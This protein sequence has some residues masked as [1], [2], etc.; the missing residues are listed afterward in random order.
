MLQ[1]IW[2]IL[3]NFH[4]ENP[5]PESQ[6]RKT[7]KKRVLQKTGSKLH[8]GRTSSTPS[9]LCDFK[10]LENKTG[11][12]ATVLCVLSGVPHLWVARASFWG[13]TGP[14]IGDGPSAVLFRR[15]A[16]LGGKWIS[17][18]AARFARPWRLA[19]LARHGSLRS[20]ARFARTGR[21]ASL[22]GSLLGRHGSLR[23]AARFA[24]TGRLASLGGSLR[25]LLASRIARPSLFASLAR[26]GSLRSA[27]RFARTGPPQGSPQRPR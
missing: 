9:C 27:A 20:A 14:R 16:S 7:P 21:L 19:S 12:C 2:T 15:L 18:V 10:L 25:P 26:H 24:R 11:S 5:K 8:R 22:G 1:K 23:S 17:L 4:C 3:I 13:F 6:I